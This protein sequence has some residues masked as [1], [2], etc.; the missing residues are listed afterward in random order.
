MKLLKKYEIERIVQTYQDLI[1]SEINLERKDVLIKNK[2]S[3]EK[4]LIE[5]WL[6]DLK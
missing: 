5:E 3:F 4:Q 1:N 6:D 2:N